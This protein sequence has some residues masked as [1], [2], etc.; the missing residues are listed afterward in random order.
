MFVLDADQLLLEWAKD[1]FPGWAREQVDRHNKYVAQ[2]LEHNKRNPDYAYNVDH[3]G[4]IQ[5]HVLAHLINCRSTRITA[6]DHEWECNC[7]S[8]YTRDDEWVVHT[9]V[10]CYHDIAYDMR[11]RF[12]GYSM[13]EV[14]RELSQMDE[15]CQ[16]DDLDY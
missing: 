12:S 3:V 15:G 10:S 14:L 9:R 5:A 8:E 13:P 4:V 1:K 11:I 2:V 6:V 7:Y 16:Y